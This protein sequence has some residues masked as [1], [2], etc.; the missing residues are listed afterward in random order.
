VRDTSPAAL[1]SL[2]ASNQQ[3]VDQMVKEL[4]SQAQFVSYAPPKFMALRQGIYLELSLNSN[5]PASDAG[6]RCKLAAMAFDDH[7]AQLIRPLLAYFKEEQ[8]FDGIGFSTTV[9]LVGKSATGHL[10]S[11]EILLSAFVVAL[12]REIRLHPPATPGHWNRADQWRTCG[13]RSANRGGRHQP[14]SCFN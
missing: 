12:L 8:K 9:H 5:L 11:R 3:V 13:P 7:V 4:D 2:Q 14:L 10:R 1:S 6:S